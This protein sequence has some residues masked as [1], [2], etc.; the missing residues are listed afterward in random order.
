M[1]RVS[2]GLYSIGSPNDSSPVFV[3]ANYTLSFDALRWA[4]A[5][6]DSYIL[7]LDT[8]G[9][10]VWCAAGKGTFG[11][12]ELVR[13]INITGLKDFVSHRKLIVPQLGAS[14]INAFEVKKKS[15]FQV[16]FGPVRAED[17]PEYLRSGIITTQMRRV[18][19]NLSDRLVLIPVEMTHVLLP[20]F[21]I[22][23]VLFLLFG[24]LAA[25][26][27]FSS[28]FAGIVLFP[29]LLPYIPTKDFSS[30][31]FILGLVIS[32]PFAWLAIMNGNIWEKYLLAVAFLFAMPAIT[33]FISLNFTGSTPFASRTGVRR[34]IFR[35]IPIMAGMIIVSIALL[36]AMALMKIGGII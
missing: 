8:K 34:E 23:I 29:L 1:H 4:L 5:G 19:F 21:I 9:I 15:G 14:G 28:M 27:F 36:I 33:A 10:N 30:K 31:G 18:R 32:L 24:I 26:A 35:Y 2:P 17:I 22:S 25:G 7:V 12:K 13:R 6:I 3:T 20:A 11:T 16:E